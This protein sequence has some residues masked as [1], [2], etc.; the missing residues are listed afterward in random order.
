MRRREFL[1]VLGGAATTWPLAAQ[2]QQS[3]MPVVGYLNAGSPDSRPGYLPA[4]RQGLAEAGYVEGQNVAIE[5]RWAGNQFD[6]LPGLADDLVRRK[7]VVIAATGGP[8]A[9]LAAK[10]ATATIP[11]VFT[12]GADPVALGL[13]TSLNRPGGNIT[14][15]SLLYA[16]LGAKRLGLLREL[17]PKADAIGFLVNPNFL[18]GQT[19]LREVVARASGQQLIIL[20]ASSDSEIDLAFTTL[21]QRKAGGLVVASDP[22]FSSQRGRI[23][24][25]AARHA[26]P[27]MYFDRAFVAAGGL[28]S[29][30]ASI[31]DMYRAAG[32]YGGRILKG[33]K[34]A[35]LPVQQPNKFELAINLN[36]AKTL[37]LDVP[38]HLQQIAD[39]V[40]E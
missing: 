8:S 20:N 17:T 5:Y 2:A 40:I 38:L 35:D 34:P 29:Y 33:E 15:V 13:V 3:A 37:G 9:A 39:E 16:E 22:F 24:A 1:G 14:G 28:M 6:R 21:V 30:G 18:E 19:Q 7:V 23:I 12:S 36:T 4:F 11:I 26:I 25:L 27:A 32:V 10:S 31:Q